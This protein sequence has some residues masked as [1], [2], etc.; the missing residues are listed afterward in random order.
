MD[1]S[2]KG[3]ILAAGVIITCIVVG[4]GFF[5]S[6]EAKNASDSGTN[7]LSAMSSQ[8]ANVE[9]AM[10]DGLKV[11]GSEVANVIKNH[12]GRIQVMVKTKA[13][14]GGKTYNSTSLSKVNKSDVDYINPSALFLGELVKNVNEEVT[15]IVFTQQ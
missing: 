13:N 6:R 8:Y 7:Q 9:F 1:N 3:L 14:T 5:I 2:L 11:T 4:L 15:E 12:G 10:Y